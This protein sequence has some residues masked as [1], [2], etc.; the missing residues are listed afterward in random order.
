MDGESSGTKES[1]ALGLLERD[2]RETKLKRSVNGHLQ[3]GRFYYLY[4]LNS[5]QSPSKCDQEASFV[6]TWGYLLKIHHHLLH[7]GLGW[8]AWE[9]AF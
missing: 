2:V 5:Q 3:G 1:C 7:Q 4:V 6:R 9:S 8:G